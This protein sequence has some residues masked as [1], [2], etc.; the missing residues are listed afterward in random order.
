MSLKEEKGKTKWKAIFAIY[1]DLKLFLEILI[2]LIV[3]V[4]FKK[5]LELYF[6]KSF[7]K[8]FFQYFESNEYTISAW[9]IG[10][11]ILTLSVF[12]LSKKWKPWGR[13]S[14]NQAIVFAFICIIYSVFYRNNQ[15]W[16]N[17][18][19]TTSGILQNLKYADVI[20]PYPI[21]N[22]IS[23]IIFFSRQSV[24][25][26]VNRGFKEDAHITEEKQDDL[27][28]NDYAK[29]VSK[30]ISK[31]YPTKSICIGVNGQWGSGKTSFIHLITG[32]LKANPTITSFWFNPWESDSLDQIKQ[33]F[34]NKLLLALPDKNRSLKDL[35]L[36]YADQINALNPNIYTRIRSFFTQKKSSYDE[37]YRTNIGE[38]LKVSGQ[39]L[40]VIIDDLD[41]LDAH[42][43]AEVF[44]IVRN[45]VNFNNVI[46]IMA[47][48]RNYIDKTIA[49]KKVN[50]DG[51]FL[52][53]IVQTEIS[54]PFIRRERLVN[55]LVINVQEI[56]ENLDNRIVPQEALNQI[57]DEIRSTLTV[58]GYHEFYFDHFIKNL[59][60]VARITNSLKVN[61]PEIHNEIYFPDLLMLEML[62]LR[63][64]VVYDIIQ[65]RWY[66][67]LNSPSSFDNCYTVKYDKIKG[68]VFESILEKLNMDPSEIKNL[69]EF[70]KK[71]F[72]KDANDRK[73][74]NRIYS[75]QKFNI[76]FSHYLGEDE[77]SDAAYESLKNGDSEEFLNFVENCIFQ[78]N[79]K[80]L[81]KRFEE[82]SIQRIQS[83]V[84]FENV[85][86]GIFFLTNCKSRVDDKLPYFIAYTN[87]TL[88][89]WMF[90]FDLSIR[91][92]F[93]SEDSQLKEFYSGLLKQ[94]VE[95][96]YGFSSELTKNL[97]EFAV[98]GEKLDSTGNLL[99]NSDDLIEKNIFHLEQLTNKAD[100]Y[101]YQ[102]EATY[103]NCY[104]RIQDDSSELDRFPVKSQ[105]IIKSFVFNNHLA[106]LLMSFIQETPNPRRTYRKYSYAINA[107]RVNYYFQNIND[108]I[109]F[110]KATNENGWKH[111]HEYTKFCLKCVDQEDINTPII[112][113]FSKPFLHDFKIFEKEFYTPLDLHKQKSV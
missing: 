6:E 19:L 9:F 84:A 107:K 62:K 3:F 91:K 93:Y 70:V 66:E 14:L 65:S 16:I 1:V 15:V 103:S 106:F 28:Y 11:V 47:Y 58:Q 96:G 23:W 99:F 95:S 92:K 113:D 12:G 68:T 49:G 64:P 17:I 59:R 26:N 41:R 108:F 109:D 37:R 101:N 55:Q 78:G 79:E 76:Y 13:S 21:A 7:I 82:E 89:M 104:I 61:L 25:N 63:Y 67:V 27:G 40:V 77:F 83:R 57:E 4:L 72:P 51:M 87:R 94:G 31:T 112:Y 30:E 110:L 48:D 98:Q 38:V 85:M 35:F 42:E 45:S 53:K 5:P 73:G 34:F 36:K 33:D 74:I 10:N 43:L 56:L 90:D 52:N 20:I 88:L 39:R 105:E 69:V 111:L 46:F 86:K 8:F 102:V 44:K 18:P 32:Y 60:D 2:I 100:E 81:V 71:M 80:H 54:L 75:E 22:L 24:V 97:R 29:V 50:E